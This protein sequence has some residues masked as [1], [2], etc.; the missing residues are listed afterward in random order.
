MKD[1]IV[2]MGSKD[3]A[4]EDIGIL[5]RQFYDSPQNIIVSGE[6]IRD[7]VAGIA[8]SLFLE[9]RIVL[10]L[11]DPG[12]E[13]IDE[14]R[15]HL[16]SLKG[17]VPVIIYMTSETKPVLPGVE[18]EVVVMEKESDKRV[19]D[20]VTALLK[21]YG[22]QMT[23][24]AFE[25]LKERIRDEAV[26][27][28]ELMKLINYSGD[29]KRI[30]SKDVLAITAQT[31]QDDLIGFFDAFSNKDKKKMMYIL[32]NLINTM[33]LPLDTAIIII[34]S[35]LVKQTRLLLHAKDTE[36]RSGPYTKYPDFTKILN[37]WKDSMD[38]KPVEKKQYLPFQKGFYAYKLSNI[39]R[40]FDK[41]DLISFLDT[42]S[43]I[44]LA[45]KRGPEHERRIILET[46]LLE[47]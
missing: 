22:K 16:V 1:I 5:S 24:K 47:I 26:L 46:G 11:I 18:A 23:D 28:T 7:T 40:K 41:K 45:I 32:D 29:K 8:S 33:N 3:N 19:K 4:H 21:R 25:L 31:H 15:T 43:K 17:R 30:D 35:Y 14:I 27:E 37:R 13:I 44:D 6:G 34:H 9:D 2:A 36:D 10:T 42:L 20:R 38:I 12:K 39:S